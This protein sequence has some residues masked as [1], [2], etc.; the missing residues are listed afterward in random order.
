[1]SFYETV[2][3]LAEDNRRGNV[4]IRKLIVWLQ[5]E[6]RCAAEL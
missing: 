1:M 4:Q 6:Y 5:S 3:S 2:L